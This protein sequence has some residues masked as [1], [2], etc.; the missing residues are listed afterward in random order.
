M[1]INEPCDKKTVLPHVTEILSHF[2]IH[3]EEL[4]VIKNCNFS[5]KISKSYVHE[6]QEIKDM[7]S[8]FCKEESFSSLH[9]K[10]LSAG[11][12]LRKKKKKI[13]KTFTICLLH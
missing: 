10:N 13:S 5:L 7:I 1:Y 2:E 9:S 8:S 4:E 3:K 6:Y 11:N 12:S